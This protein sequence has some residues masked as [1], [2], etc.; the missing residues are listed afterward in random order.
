MVGYT[1]VSAVFQGDVVSNE[2]VLCQ[3]MYHKMHG[4]VM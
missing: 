1:Y 4:L 2:D 3:D